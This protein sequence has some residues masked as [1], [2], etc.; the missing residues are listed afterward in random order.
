MPKP[1]LN[2]SKALS[3]NP[4]E[5]DSTHLS[6]TQKLSKVIEDPKAFLSSTY[7]Y[8]SSSTTPTATIQLDSRN[9]Q[10]NQ[11]ATKTSRN[12]VGG[13]ITQQ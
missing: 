11:Q 5:A 4:Y 1:L 6:H 10:N 2:V 12:I 8:N 13:V 3:S 9:P 7:T